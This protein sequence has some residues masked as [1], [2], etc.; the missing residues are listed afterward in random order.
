MLAVVAVGCSKTVPGGHKITTPTPVS[1]VG[2]LPK[3]PSQAGNP[4]AGKQLFV[5][6][7]CGAC[8]TFTPAGTKGTVGPNLDN[9]PAYA[10]AANQGT[11]PEFINTSI[12]DPTAYVAPGYRNGIMPVTY[13][14]S[15]KPQELN[16]LVAFLAKGTGS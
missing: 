13:G 7:G 9:L 8:H 16:D 11:L 5:S 12:V 14:T 15:L 2:P 6:Q 1:V 4:V 10:K 3:P